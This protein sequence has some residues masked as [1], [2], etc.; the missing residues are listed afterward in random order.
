ME[1]NDDVICIYDN[2]KEAID[3]KVLDIFE[4]YIERKLEING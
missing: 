4:I 2:E 1:S 3:K